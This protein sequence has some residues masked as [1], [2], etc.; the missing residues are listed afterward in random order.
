MLTKGDIH[1]LDIAYP[2]IKACILSFKKYKNLFNL[3]QIFTQ[4]SWVHSRT[5]LLAP[6][7]N[8]QYQE[9]SGTAESECSQCQIAFPED[10]T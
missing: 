10:Y 8:I 9:N 3:I 6:S 2:A 4:Q 7:P 5:E 1:A